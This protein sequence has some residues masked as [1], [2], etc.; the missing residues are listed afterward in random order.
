M[1]LLFFVCALRFYLLYGGVICAATSYILQD[2]AK[3]HT[4]HP[5]CL[6]YFCRAFL[7]VE[8]QFLS[9]R[10]KAMPTCSWHS[11]PAREAGLST[12]MQT[13]RLP[14]HKREK[15]RRCFCGTL[16]ISDFTFVVS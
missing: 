16:C 9:Y 10:K 14:P 12:G 4:L 5:V 3:K 13:E 7:I 1:L 15:E 6:R 11:G 2:V 8:Q